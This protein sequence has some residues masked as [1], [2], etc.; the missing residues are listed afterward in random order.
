MEEQVEPKEMREGM[1]NEC[2]HEQ[3]LQCIKTGCC[4][5]AVLGLEDLAVIRTGQAQ[6]TPL[7]KTLSNTSSI[8][9]HWRNWVPADAGYH[10]DRQK[11][12][13]RKTSVQNSFCMSMNLFQPTVTRLLQ[14]KAML[15]LNTSCHRWLFLLSFRLT[16][17]A[18]GKGIFRLWIVQIVHI[19]VECCCHSYL[20]VQN[21]NS[22]LN[23]HPKHL[24]K[25]S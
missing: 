15:R 3:M 9:A 18:L 23:K 7:R 21:L 1:Q 14:P 22:Q 17:S 8:G 2:W 6:S 19:S 25:K 4:T 13:V 10:L 5:W 16:A 12:L 11:Y 20:K 24:L